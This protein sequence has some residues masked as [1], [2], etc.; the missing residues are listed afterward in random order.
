MNMRP[1]PHQPG[2]IASYADYGF[3]RVLQF[4]DSCCCLLVPARQPRY[5]RNDLRQ[6][7]GTWQGAAS[8]SEVALYI[9][10]A[11]ILTEGWLQAHSLC[12]PAQLLQPVG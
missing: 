10:M 8:S 2:G 11:L 7:C 4:A 5:I 12:Q 6:S 9:K 3:A 1:T